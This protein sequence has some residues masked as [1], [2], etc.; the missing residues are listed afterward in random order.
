MAVSYFKETLSSCNQKIKN[1]LLC[2]RDGDIP[3]EGTWVEVTGVLDS[4]VEEEN[5]YILVRVSNLEVRDEI[6]K[7]F[8]TE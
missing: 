3:E 5:E 2:T 4:Y 6:G 7:T 1:Y 8:V